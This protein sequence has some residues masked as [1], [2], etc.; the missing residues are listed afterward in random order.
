[1]KL[2]WT[3][4][5]LFAGIVAMCLLSFFASRS[6]APSDFVWA[7]VS[8]VGLI[9]GSNAWQAAQIAKHANRAFG[10]DIHEKQRPKNQKS[11]LSK[12]K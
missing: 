5:R 10:D 2:L 8:I 7:I 12:D 6:S 9:S 11:E 4:R 3:D 1:M